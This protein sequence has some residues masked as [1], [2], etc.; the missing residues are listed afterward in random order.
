MLGIFL[1]LAFL[2]VI[3]F[4][5]IKFPINN[6]LKAVIIFTVF[7]IRIMCP[8]G[9]TCLPADCCFSELTLKSPT[10]PVG[11]E[12]SGPHHHLIEN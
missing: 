6:D 12:Q 4:I 5:I 10:Q 1:Q 8:S 2:P 9:A 3:L 7:G 11:L